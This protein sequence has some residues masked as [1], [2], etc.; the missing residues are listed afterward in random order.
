MDE[1]ESKEIDVEEEEVD[2]GVIVQALSDI[3]NSG[4]KNNFRFIISLNV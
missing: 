3:T 2:K 1:E 4:S